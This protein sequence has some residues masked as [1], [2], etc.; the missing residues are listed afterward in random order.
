MACFRE[1]FAHIQSN[2][3][4][5]TIQHMSDIHFSLAFHVRHVDFHR[6]FNEFAWFTCKA[7]SS[8]SSLDGNPVQVDRH[9][10]SVLHVTL[11]HEGNI[12]GII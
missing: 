7:D 2:A 10:L 12:L 3:W 5:D 1:S 11:A 9:F 6:V 4:I 8:K